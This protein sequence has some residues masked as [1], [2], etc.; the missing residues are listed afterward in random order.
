MENTNEKTDDQY[1]QEMVDEFLLE[2]KTIEKEIFENQNSVKEIDLYIQS[3]FEKEDVDYE[4]FSPRNIKNIYKDKIDSQKKEK[5]EFL[6]KNA[7]LNNRLSIINERISSLN[8]VITNTYLKNEKY[9]N[10]TNISSVILDIQEKERQR[11]AR[12]LHD[13]TVQNLTHLIHK[14][15]LSTK[16]MDQD[17]IR[18]KM[19]LMDISKNIKEIINDMRNI[20]FNLRP[21]EFD[22]I[23]LKA[24]FEKFITEVMYKSK[25]DMEYDIDEITLY[26]ELSDISIYHIVKECIYNSVKHSKGNH[27]IVKIKNMD[28]NIIIL[29][30]DNGI[31]FDVN[32]NF[33][34]RHFGLSLI[35]ESVSILKGKIDINS[36]INEG[37]TISICI[38]QCS[39]GSNK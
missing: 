6:K 26:N 9:I 8:H 20:I 37:T 19:E 39:E 4:V 14:I 29:I 2:K 18:A 12:D 13:N 35:K 21:M 11:I 31:G 25:I 5:N 3:L 27:L 15:E 32:A 36:I 28:S 16:F 24:T 23:G 1:L 38:P 22:D 34:K 33:D 17:T 10:S 30:Q 7:L